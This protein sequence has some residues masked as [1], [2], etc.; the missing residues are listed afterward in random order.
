MCVTFTE[1][2][3]LKNTLVGAIA[4]FSP[5]HHQERKKKFKN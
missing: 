1:V 4:N 5:F 2:E 3:L